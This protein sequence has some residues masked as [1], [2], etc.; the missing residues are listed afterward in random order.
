MEEK[1]IFRTA[2]TDIHFN[3]ATEKYLIEAFNPASTVLF[4]W[5]NS[6]TVV[7]GRYQNPWEECKL[8][9][10][11]KDGV[12]LARRC[13]GGGAVYQDLGNICFTLITPVEK[14]NKAKNFTV[15]LKALESMGIK[16]QLSGRNDILVEGRKVSGSAFQT[17]CG[18]F[19]HHGT[20]LISTDLTKLPNYLTPNQK[21]LENHGV[22]S[23]SS[24]VAK[25]SDFLPSAT[26]ELFATCMAEAFN[27][28][29]REATEF[30]K[31]CP[32]EFITKEKLMDYPE[33]RQSFETFSSKAWNFGKC[34][35]FTDKLS[36]RLP[37]GV[38]TFYLTVKKGCIT[39]AS[40]STDALQAQG[41]D[42][43]LEELE[44][45]LVGLPYEASEINQVAD[46]ITDKK[47]AHDFVCDS[48]RLLASLIIRE[49]T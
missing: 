40:V 11:E 22:K 47:I 34:P 41:L 33:F 43:S 15:V 18:R 7:I 37:C 4:L 16:A 3:L 17:T 2:E 36:G 12:T 42:Q 31:Q 21:K 10:L 26:T 35:T 44:K 5:Q 9:N 13:S 29:F 1:R 28:V 19:C 38:V 32:I 14:A 49:R 24:R 20:M 23:V 6:P 27:E 30:S 45:T 39:A 8:G 46:K 48:L 25:L